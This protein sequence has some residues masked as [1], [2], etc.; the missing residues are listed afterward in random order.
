MADKYRVT[1]ATYTTVITDDGVEMQKHEAVDYVPGDI[2]DAYVADASTKWQQVVVS[3]EVDAGPGGSN[4]P[5]YI[6]EQLNVPDA[7]TFTPAT[8]E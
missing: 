5:T 4:G 2:L 6:P 3:D 8:E 7:G 1:M